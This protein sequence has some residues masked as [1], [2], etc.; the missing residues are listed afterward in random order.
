[1]V[2][3]IWSLV[4]RGNLLAALAINRREA[5]IADDHFGAGCNVAHLAGDFD[6]L[7]LGGLAEALFELGEFLTAF[8]A[9]FDFFFAFADG[10]ENVSGWDGQSCP[11]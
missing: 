6:L 2:I 1:M 9:A 7:A 3:G 5:P 10:Q 4:I 11:S 8:A